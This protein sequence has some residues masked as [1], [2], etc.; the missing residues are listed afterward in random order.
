MK[1]LDRASPPLDIDSQVHIPVVR[2][3]V[4]P[5]AESVHGWEEFGEVGGVGGSKVVED[6]FAVFGDFIFG[7]VGVWFFAEFFEGFDG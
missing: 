2:G 1:E 3:V 7:V 4:V 5:N 6:G